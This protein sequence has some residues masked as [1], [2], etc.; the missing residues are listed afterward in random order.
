MIGQTIICLS[1]MKPYS[2]MKMFNLW[3]SNKTLM[4]T[5]QRTIT[6]TKINSLQVSS[7]EVNGYGL[8]LGIR[9]IHLDCI[10][11]TLK[12]MCIGM[13]L[14]WKLQ[15]LVLIKLALKSIL[16]TI[17]MG[18]LEDWST[19]VSFLMGI[20]VRKTSIMCLRTPVTVF[21][22]SDLVLVEFMKGLIT[23]S[24]ICWLRLRALGMPLV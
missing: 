15:T 23:S 21:F 16:E 22:I 17:L 10:L 3:F 6:E 4:I 19:L 2:I 13:D 5:W 14:R 11:K 12:A 9:L 1:G 7:P 24:Q 18:S 8:F 20:I